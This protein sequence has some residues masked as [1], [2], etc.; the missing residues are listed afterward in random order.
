M[1]PIAFPDPVPLT[2]SD[3]EVV[4]SVKIHSCASEASGN[5]LMAREC[6][7]SAQGPNAELIV[8]RDGELV[9]IAHEG[10]SYY[11]D[12]RLLK[13]GKNGSCV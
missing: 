2:D 3:G 1:H 12:S 5:V 8:G 4:F 11:G 10:A 6:E 9:V 7:L 13:I